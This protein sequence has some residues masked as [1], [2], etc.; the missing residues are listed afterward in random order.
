MDWR[1]IHPCWSDGGGGGE[2]D[3]NGL[4]NFGAGR[5]GFQDGDGG[6]LLYEG[7]RQLSSDV[8]IL[9]KESERI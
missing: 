7:I 5:G 8:F 4:D 6:G 9:I 3:E 2:R 1:S